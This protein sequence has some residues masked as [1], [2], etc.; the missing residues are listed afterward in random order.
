MTDFQLSRP[1]NHI[2][3]V[4]TMFADV[5]NT[6][7]RNYEK[8]SSLMG[9]SQNVLWKVKSL[10]NFCKAAAQYV[11]N[12]VETSRSKYIFPDDY[13]IIST[14]KTKIVYRLL[15]DTQT[16]YND[17][18]RYF[19]LPAD[20]ISHDAITEYVTSNI[21]YIESVTAKSKTQLDLVPSK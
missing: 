15:V 6:P 16:F 8:L 10:D 4:G 14:Y 3:W 1:K 7:I 12:F 2:A 21:V 20:Q 11:I 5:K 19:R 13:I 9:V 17:L 18:D